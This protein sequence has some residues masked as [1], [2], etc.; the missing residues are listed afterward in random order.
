MWLSA[1]V[2][3]LMELPFTLDDNHQW[4]QCYHFQIAHTTLK[5]QFMILHACHKQQQ[6]WWWFSMQFKYLVY[7]KCTVALTSNLEHGC[8]WRVI[9]NCF[10][11]TYTGK[12]SL[13]TFPSKTFVS[14]LQHCKLTTIC[15]QYFFNWWQA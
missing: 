4:Y 9:M 11:N 12:T 13:F 15:L 6:F 2:S 10:P 3:S 7:N 5:F 14:I 1:T 8:S